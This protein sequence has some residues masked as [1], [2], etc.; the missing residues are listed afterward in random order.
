MSASSTTPCRGPISLA[1]LTLA[2]V[3]AAAPAFGPG[4]AAQGAPDLTVTIRLFEGAVASSPAGRTI[5]ITDTTRNVGLAEAGPSTTWFILVGGKTER[6]TFILLGSRAIPALAGSAADTFTSVFALPD[7]APHTFRI[8]AQAD[9]EAAVIEGDEG[10]NYS[11]D[12][13]VIAPELALSGLTIASGGTVAQDRTRNR[14]EDTGVPASI[15]QFY[16]STDG[17]LD[18]GDIPI[19]SRTVPA[20]GPGGSDKADTP[21]TLPPGLVAGTYFVMAL[22]DAHVAYDE[23]DEDNNARASEPV[24]FVPDVI[25]SSLTVPRKA[26]AGETIAVTDAT[27][28]RGG[29]RAPASTTGYFLSHDRVLDGSDV[30]LGIRAVPALDIGASSVETVTVGIPDTT[31]PGC[32][33]IIAAADIEQVIAESGETNNARPRPIQVR[34]PGASKLLCAENDLNGDRRSDLVWRHTA[35]DVAV[36]LMDGNVFS[37]AAMVANPSLDWTI[38]G[39]GDFNG[40]GTSD[41]VWRQSPSGAVGIWLMKGTALDSAVIVDNPSLQWS[42]AGV[43]DFDGDGTADLLWRESPSGAVGIWLMDGTTRVSAEIIASRALDWTVAGVGDFN[44]DG[45]ADIAWRE[46][47]SGAVEIWLMDGAGVGSAAF[48]AHAPLDWAIAGV[49]EFNGDAK[50]D[51]LWRQSHSGDVGIWLMDG[52]SLVSAAVVGGSSLEWA[53]ARVGDFNGDGKADVLWRDTTDWVGVW[54]MNGTAVSGTGFSAF[55]GLQGWVVQ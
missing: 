15:T 42:I 37:S 25:V 53:I 10:N 47:S 45:K 2:T 6:S 30:P 46:A 41:L 26:V 29:A 32:Y 9:A 12:S 8:F 21:L 35:G 39:S 34:L 33:F 31:A 18:A 16:L 40:D 19:G 54:F 5:T 51:L 38:V 52:T 13:R 43:G 55:P 22:A 20:L 4:A 28:S 11:K 48:V 50:A 23:I 49:G 36:W 7:T 17:T 44:D 24:T 3:L 1:L 27:T 14:S